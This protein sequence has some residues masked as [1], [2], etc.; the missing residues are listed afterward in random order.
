M[1]L[2]ADILSGGVEKALTTPG[3]DICEKVISTYAFS[4]YILI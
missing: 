2:L 1:N 4:S 3:E